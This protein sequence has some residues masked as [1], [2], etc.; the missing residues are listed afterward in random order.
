M[1]FVEA[2]GAL[3]TSHAVERTMKVHQVII[4]AMSGEG[5]VMIL[6]KPSLLKFPSDGCVLIE[7]GQTQRI[8]ELASSTRARL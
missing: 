3:L 8:S 1:L 2:H 4:R 7:R 6:P 5:I